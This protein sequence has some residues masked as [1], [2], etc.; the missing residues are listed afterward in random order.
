MSKFAAS[1]IA[2]IAGS[3]L[4][5]SLGPAGAADMVL[6]AP[7]EK[8]P[9]WINDYVPMFGDFELLQSHISATRGAFKI[10]ENES[11][12]PV[13]RVY[14]N[15]NLFN[16]VDQGPL[17]GR[18]DV[19]RYTFGYEK[20]FFGGQASAGVRIPFFNNLT[21]DSEN[22]FGDLSVLLKY[23]L[24]NDQA[25]GNLISTGLVV[26]LPTGT[27][28][29]RFDSLDGNAHSTMLQ[30]FVGWQWNY[31]NL[32]VQG[33]HSI[34]VPTVSRDVSFL[35]N[36]IGVG[37]WL[38]RTNQNQFITGIAPVIELHVNTPLTHSE[39]NGSINDRSVTNLVFGV[40]A[41]IYNQFNFGAALGVPLNGPRPYDV[42]A[43][44]HLNFRF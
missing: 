8:L 33:F 23:A 37:Y 35:F 36:D 10:A 3:V 15:Y 12:R 24:Y 4:C 29:H 28:P 42:E 34:M 18:Q 43:M 13:D 30:P 38:Y 17:F 44:A 20:T 26:T 9:A 2:C 7:V 25:T 32:F 14:F 22:N 6:K 41:Q 31:G 21:G 27:L 19:S 40:N 11:P 5:A 1:A 16:N 39:D